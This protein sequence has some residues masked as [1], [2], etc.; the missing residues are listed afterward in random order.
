MLGGAWCM[1]VPSRSG[2]LKVV[3]TYNIISKG[4]RERAR[5]F[6]GGGDIK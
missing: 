3:D 2:L 5:Q 1:Y 6:I 4:E